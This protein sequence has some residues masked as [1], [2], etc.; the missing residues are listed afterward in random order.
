MLRDD[1][2]TVPAIAVT[3]LFVYGS[4]RAGD[5][6]HDVIAPYTTASEPATARGAMVALP[7]GYPGVTAGGDGTIVGE[8]VELHDLASAW[9]DLDAYEGEEFERVLVDVTT[10]AGRVWAW[11]YVLAT[12]SLA[13]TGTPIAHGDWRRYRAERA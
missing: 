13:A 7:D 1:R 8:V 4:L 11:M 10:A 2:R 6:A 5:V 3:R 9:R 12:A